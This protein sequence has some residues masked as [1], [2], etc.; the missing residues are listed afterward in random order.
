[1]QEIHVDDYGW[2]IY[3]DVKDQD[4]NPS[5][6]TLV[7]SVQVSFFKSNNVGP[8]LRDASFVTDGSDGKIYYT[9]QDG[10]ID[11]PGTWQ[12]QVVVTASSY[13]LRSNI[14]K[15]KVFRNL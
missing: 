13:V 6:L 12:M 7:E 1:M 15:F 14:V 8:V 10:D 9:V 11:E 2:T 4:E 3:I 5:D